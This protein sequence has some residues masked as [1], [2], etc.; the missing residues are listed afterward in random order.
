MTVMRK[1]LFT[2]VVAIVA[3]ASAVCVDAKSSS[4]KSLMEAVI[5][6]LA[7]TA[8]AHAAI[9]KA[10]MGDRARVTSTRTAIAK[11]NEARRLVNAFA[12]SD[13]E[14]TA[15]LASGFS[16]AYEVLARLLT[17]S[18]QIQ[19]VTSERTVLMDEAWQMFADASAAST[20]AF[21]D[22]ERP[23][24]DGEYR[25]LRITAKDVADLR[26]RLERRFDKQ[27]LQPQGG[28]LHAVQFAPAALWLVLE[29]GK[30]SD[31]ASSPR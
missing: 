23:D 20:I 2:A 4:F 31:F 30:P 11:L 13:D 12:K 10:G 18:L 3:L 22:Y 14:L 9:T 29:Q 15:E 7:V 27:A 26:V 6:S 25:T 17:E 16:D 1:S 5:D 8:D 28:N 19:I 24:A 21:I